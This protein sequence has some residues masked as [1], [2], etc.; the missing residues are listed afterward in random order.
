MSPDRYRHILQL[1]DQQGI[2]RAGDITAHNSPRI[3]LQRLVERGDLALC[4]D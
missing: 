4:G 2:L 3:Y 1:V